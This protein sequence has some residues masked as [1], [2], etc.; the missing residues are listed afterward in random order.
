MNQNRYLKLMHLAQFCN[1]INV[2][3]SKY[4]FKGKKK[5]TKKKYFFDYLAQLSNLDKFIFT[6]RQELTSTLKKKISG[7]DS[8]VCT[9]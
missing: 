5:R 3:H 9:G 1:N 7:L 8:D 2:W 4:F 6:T